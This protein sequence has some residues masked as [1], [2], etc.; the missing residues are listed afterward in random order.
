VVAVTPFVLDYQG[1]PFLNFSWRLPSAEASEE[2][3]FYQQYYTVQSLEKTKGQPTQIEKGEL[4]FNFPNELVA[5]SSFHFRLTLKN[6]GQ[7]IWD[8]ND[9]YHLT[10]ENYDSAQYF[11]SDLKKIKPNNISDVDLYLKTTSQLGKSRTKIILAKGKQTVAESNSWTFEVMP[12]PEIDINLS[13]FPKIRTNDSNFELQIFNDQQELVYKKQGIE[14]E[15]NLAKV[16][17]VQN[18]AFGRKYRLVLLR[19]YYLPRQAYTVLKKGINTITFRKMYPLDFNLDG[20]LDGQDIG[21]FFSNLKLFGL[22]L[23]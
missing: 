11:F 10:L 16:D 22:F 19:P 1:E 2:Q 6:L 3:T 5:E 21:A 14:A 23:P 15:N 20:K 18:V 8:K 7:A 9:D 12:L 13:L 17:N 4:K